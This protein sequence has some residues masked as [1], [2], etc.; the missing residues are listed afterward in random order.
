MEVS[1]YGYRVKWKGAEYC[2]WGYSTMTGAAANI[3]ADLRR[4][5]WRPARWWEFWRPRTP[6][7]L[8]AEYEWQT[9]Q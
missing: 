1:S 6:P 2:N 3:V 9:K 4:D 5:G 8:R 7:T